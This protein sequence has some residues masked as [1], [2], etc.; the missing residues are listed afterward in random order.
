MQRII[1]S[2]AP[3]RIC[4]LGGWTDTW[5]AGHG[6][7]LNLSVYPYV[8]C[9]MAVAPAVGGRGR[10]T[11]HAENYGERYTIDPDSIVYDK[12]PL[13]EAA[14]DAMA[15]PRDLDIEVT[16]YSEAPAGCSTGT[17]AAVSVALIG[18]LDALTP[19]RMTPGEVAAKA[20]EIETR[21]LGLQC[22]IQDQIA[23]AY[24]G[25]CY[26]EMTRY[27]DARVSHVEIPNAIWWELEARLSLVFL[28]RTHRSSSVH[29]KVISELEG[30][31]SDCPKIEQLRRPPLTGKN[32][33]FSGD[34]ESLGGAMRDNTAYQ[35]DLHPSL[36]SETA[37]QVIDVA[38]RH[39]ALGWKVNGAGG[40][41]GSV[42]LLSDGSRSRRRTMLKEIE[43]LDPSIRAIFIY[44]S[45]H[46]LRVW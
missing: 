24:G 15:V 44:L 36:V 35:A 32:A 38:R 14:I 28:G 21:Y 3:I 42:T 22:G 23:S 31:G 4:D 26:I 2:V 25:I 8:Q 10:V 6:N 40:E 30:A 34:F 45:R 9:Q 7:V 41:G 1:N 11:L 37:H 17:S 46:G 39:G 19:G 43:A 33:L 27:P 16:V 20:H 12:H 18:A 29:E 5:F 13:L